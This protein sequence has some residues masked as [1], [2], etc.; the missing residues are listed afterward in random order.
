MAKIVSG[1]GYKNVGRP[2]FRGM[3][4]R[5]SNTTKAAIRRIMRND[6][7]VGVTQPGADK[8]TTTH[9]DIVHPSAGKLNQSDYRRV[10]TSYASG[11]KAVKKAVARIRKR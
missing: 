6:P 3:A 9:I 5:G 11:R 4:G 7:S 8:I 10:A 1:E 2:G